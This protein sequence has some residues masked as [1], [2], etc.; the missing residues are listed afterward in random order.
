[1]ALIARRNGK[2]I[3]NS[4]ARGFRAEVNA[5][6][7]DEFISLLRH[8]AN[9]HLEDEAEKPKARRADP[10]RAAER[11]AA[12]AAEEKAAAK[13]EKQATKITFACKLSDD[14][15]ET[16]GPLA[17]VKNLITN[18]KKG[19]RTLEKATELVAGFAV[20][21]KS[22]KK[23]TA[24]AEAAIRG[25]ARMGKLKLFDEKVYLPD[26]D[27]GEAEGEADAKTGTDDE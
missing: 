1:M 22:T 16:V 27:T 5:T 18:T 3:I 24:A 17:Y 25:L 6:K 15:T 2:Y 23:A 12:K 21:T 9:H 20:G 14:A 11:A 7:V 10:E 26:A 19:Y 8:A 4:K 13:A